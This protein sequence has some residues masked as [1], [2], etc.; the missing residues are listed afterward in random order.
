MVI[1][2]LSFGDLFRHQLGTDLCQIPKVCRIKATQ[3]KYFENILTVGYVR[4]LTPGQVV[5]N[6]TNH[7][8]NTKR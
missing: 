7:S 1:Q 6:L 3:H 2:K 8:R 5:K 4:V